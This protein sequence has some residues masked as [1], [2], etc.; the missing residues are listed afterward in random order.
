M[1]AAA[2]GGGGQADEQEAQALRE[3]VLAQAAHLGMDP[4]ADAEFLWCV[5]RLTTACALLENSDRW[6]DG[7]MDGWIDGW[8]D[9]STGVGWLTDRRLALPTH[10]RSID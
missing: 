8:I 10:D 5:F 9:R 7:W 1:A 6:I 4:K 2:A 3:A